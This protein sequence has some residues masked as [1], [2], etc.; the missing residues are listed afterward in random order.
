MKVALLTPTFYP[1]SGIDR[2]VYSKAKEYLQ[3]GHSVDIFTLAGSLQSDAKVHIIGMPKNP[4]LQRIYRLLMFLDKKKVDLYA[5]ILSRYQMVISFLYPMNLLASKAKKLNPE[6]TYVYYN[7][8]VGIS[9]GYSS[10]E[11]LYLR[12]F[13]YLNNKT[14][15][16]ADSAISISNFLRDTLK[17]E[18]GKESAVEYV[19]VD[20]KRF[21]KL[22]K[23]KIRERYHIKKDPVLLYVGRISPHKGIHLLLDAFSVVQRSYPKAR[24]MIVGKETFGGYAKMLRR[25]ASKNV[26]FAGFVPDEELPHYYAACD[27]YTTCSFWEGFDIPIVE[28]SYAG[29]PTVCFDVGSH[30]EVLKK[31]ILVEKGNV[32]AFADAI[33]SMLKR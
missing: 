32:R 23:T 3:K 29:K 11:R 19:Y 21:K 22:D 14:I 31:G 4:S 6:L 13:N 9:E 18:T 25:K 20:A 15:R 5:N 12:Y 28:A 7:A 33:I 1:Y 24:L 27:I 16:N 2:V 8:G 26:I 10:F 30:S 17:K